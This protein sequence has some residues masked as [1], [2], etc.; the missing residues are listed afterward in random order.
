MNP[1]CN[2]RDYEFLQGTIVP[3]PRF[4][5]GGVVVNAENLPRRY[6]YSANTPNRYHH[7]QS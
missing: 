6:Q 4:S 3:I 2:I 5:L 1:P 7:D